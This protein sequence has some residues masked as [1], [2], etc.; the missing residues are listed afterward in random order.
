MR[1]FRLSLHALMIVLLASL[2][3]AA[4]FVHAHRSGVEEGPSH[5]HFAHAQAGVIHLEAD[6]ADM[7]DMGLAC[8][9]TREHAVAQVL[10]HQPDLAPA[11]RSAPPH[12]A[13]RVAMATGVAPRVRLRGCGLPPPAAAPPLTV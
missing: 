4:P 6:E 1:S 9:G 12:P 5:M 3:A 7:V 11:P 13:L 8:T 2:L 10:I